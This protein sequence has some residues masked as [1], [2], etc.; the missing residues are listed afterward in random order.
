MVGLKLSVQ[1][2]PSCHY[3]RMQIALTEDL[4]MSLV[5]SPNASWKEEN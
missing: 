5:I 4:T 3:V 2:L 1:F